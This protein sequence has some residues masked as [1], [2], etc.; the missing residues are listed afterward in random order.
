MLEE[1]ECDRDTD[2]DQREQK[3]P[4]DRSA[5]PI[6]VDQW[7]LVVAALLQLRHQALT[8]RSCVMA[9]PCKS[10]ANRRDSLLASCD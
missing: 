9:R 8:L 1:H 7:R 2:Q 10:P 4:D 5:A 6:P 3:D